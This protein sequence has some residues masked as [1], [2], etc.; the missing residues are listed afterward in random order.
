MLCPDLTSQSRPAH[1]TA[2]V[3]PFMCT[4]FAAHPPRTHTQKP[5]LV[6]S[7]WRFADARSSRERMLMSEN[8]HHPDACPRCIEHDMHAPGMQTGCQPVWGSRT[9]GVEAAGGSEG[10]I[11]LEGDGVDGAAVALL[12][13]QARP[14]LHIPQPPR[15]VVAGRAQVLPHGVH[16]HAAQPV[17]VAHECAQLLACSPAATQVRSQ[18]TSHALHLHCTLVHCGKGLWSI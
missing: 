1:N 8:P 3:Q 15:L 11:T 16:S 12:L 13:Q 6:H 7:P 4:P 18:T 17:R 9:D 5:V 14:R 10:A 2:P